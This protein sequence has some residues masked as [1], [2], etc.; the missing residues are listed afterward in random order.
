[1]N[2]S[3]EPKAEA[4]QEID[5]PILR[6]VPHAFLPESPGNVPPMKPETKER[7]DAAMKEIVDAANKMSEHAHSKNLDEFFRSA[8]KFREAAQKRLDQMLGKLPRN[9]APGAGPGGMP[10]GGNRES[11]ERSLRWTL[12]FKT[13]SGEDYLKQLAAFKAKVLIPKPPDWKSN[14]L[15][16]ELSPRGAGKPWRDQELPEMFFTDSDKTSAA[17]V[18]RALGLDFDPPHFIAFFPK[19]VEDELAAQEKSYAN[20]TEEQIHSTTFHVV[21]RNGKL[22]ITV[23]EQKPVK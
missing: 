8:D 23:K 22:V 9:G 1:M 7:F 4:G 19:D 17:K 14:L 20:R 12:I 13:T 3:D 16:E 10:S 6:R 18:A 11:I 2:S 21:P 15:F 5:T